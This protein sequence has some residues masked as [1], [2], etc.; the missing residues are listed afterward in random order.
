MLRRV[1]R[2]LRRDLEQAVDRALDVDHRH[3]QHGQQERDD[4]RGDEA[5]AERDPPVAVRR[6]SRRAGRSFAHRHLAQRASGVQDPHARV[7]DPPDAG[8]RR[9]SAAARRRRPRR[10]ASACLAIRMASSTIVITISRR[11][12]DH[13]DAEHDA[14]LPLRGSRTSARPRGVVPKSSRRVTPVHPHLLVASLVSDS[15]TGA[16]G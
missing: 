12:G 3:D 15:C 9:R 5:D 6:R 2:D 10:R 4:E 7:I 14:Q 16:Q 8:E 13:H 1:A 11:D